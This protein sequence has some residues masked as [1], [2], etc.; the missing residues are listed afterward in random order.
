MPT[1]ARSASSPRSAGLSRCPDAPSTPARSAW[2]ARAGHRCAERVAQIVEAMRL[3]KPRSL[4]RSAETPQE[5]RLVERP[6]G[7][8]VGEHEHIATALPRP[9]AE[10]VKLSR[11]LVRHRNAARRTTGL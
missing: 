1:R 5:R 8:G 10:P 4:E 7:G 9:A 2:N 3:L 11:D 6:V